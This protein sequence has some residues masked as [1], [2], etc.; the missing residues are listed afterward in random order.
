MALWIVGSAAC[1]PVNAPQP[2]SPPPFPEVASISFTGNSAFSSATLRQAMATQQRPVLP[3]WKAGE[4]YNPPTLEADVLRLKKFY[5]DRG[6]LECAVRIAQVRED[7]QRPAVHI[8]LAIDEGQPTRVVQVRLDGV[9]P[10]ALP[11]PPTLLAA[12]PLQPEQRLTKEHFEQSKARLLTHL[13]N[14]GYARAQVRPHTEVDAE[15]HTASV[16]FTL[17]PGALTVFGQTTFTGV[18]YVE[19]Q[20]L[21]RQLT[22]RPGDLATE[23]AI[24][25][26]TEAIYGLGMFQAVTPRALN[27]EAGDEPLQVNFEVI[28]RK[29]RS[30]Q[31]GLGYSTTEGFRT[32]VQWAHRNLQAQA[33]Q[34]TLEGKISSIEQKGEIRLHLPYFLAAR[35]SFTQTLFL[36]N[37]QEIDTNPL[38]ELFGAQREAQPAFDLLSAGAETR[39]AHRVHEVLSGFVGLNVSRNDFRQVNRRALTALEQEIAAD[40]ILLIQ[41]AEVQWNTSAS[42]LNPTH[43]FSLRGRLDHANS[44]LFS[45]VSFLKLLLEA[46]HYLP[47]WRQLLLATRFEIGG[48]QPYRDSQD[49]PFNVRFFAGGA[50]SVRGFPLNRLGPLNT[51]GDPIGGKSLF[52]GSTEVRFPLFGEFGAALFVDFGNV[53]R[54]TFTYHLAELRYAVG[55]GLR[56]NTP[57]G[58]VRLDVGFLLDR[59]PG[60]DFGRVEFSIG[61]AF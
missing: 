41:V 44:A 4:P 30:L 61:Q 13:H 12:L 9:L 47:L 58:P 49:V 6:F 27:Q 5:F 37:E 24:T 50:G 38:G 1:S 45:D 32:E 21:R 19:E 43:G 36:R 18:K 60:E 25:T 54:S 14:A 17:L 7:A 33:N 56:Y 8:L 48:I 46:R 10:A 51:S 16:T 26:S 59:R 35:T 11:P 3:P 15:Q 57:V 53:F 23:K 34:L 55:P 22:L 28:E 31:F 52:E 20:A 2:E 39:L 29:P 42:F 40:N